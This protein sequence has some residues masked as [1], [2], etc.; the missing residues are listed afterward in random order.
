VIEVRELGEDTWLVRGRADV[1][2]TMEWPVEDLVD[3]LKAR[4]GRDV[5]LAEPI[6]YTLD[7]SAINRY[8]RRV[9]VK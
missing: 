8:E 7:E 1:A 3:E 2:P 6:V 5:P 4:L 9:L